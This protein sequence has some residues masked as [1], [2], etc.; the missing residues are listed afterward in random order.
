[1]CSDL[2]VY[3]PDSYYS[4]MR[5]IRVAILGGSGYCSIA[6]SSGSVATIERFRERS[7][8]ARKFFRGFPHAAAVKKREHALDAYLAKF[9]RPATIS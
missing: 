8:G 5:K 4:R 7:D 6:S 9:C 2:V 1:M 3:V